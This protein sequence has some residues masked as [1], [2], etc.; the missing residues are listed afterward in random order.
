MRSD[1]YK[2]REKIFT[3]PGNRVVPVY[4]KVAD[5][6]GVVSLQ[7]TGEKD[8]YAEIQSHAESA[9]IT[10][11]MQRYEIEGDP[12][13]LNQ[14]TGVYIDTTE[15]PK[16]FAEVQGII[17]AETNRFNQLPLEIRQQFN[18]SVE[19]Y[20]A[21]IGTEKYNQFIENLNKE[22]SKKEESKKEES[23]KEESKKEE[24]KG[25]STNES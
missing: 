21:S 5:K 3:E 20:V 22:E 12:S 10:N 8:L 11:I 16:T 7:I 25:E 4:S 19:E 24:S 9:D 6:N 13:I 15:M 17:I 23:K 2:D 14:K 1:K 18:F